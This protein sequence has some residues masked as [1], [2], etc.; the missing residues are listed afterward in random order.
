MLLNEFLLGAECMS[1]LFVA[2]F[3]VRFWLRTRDRLFVF[4]S[5]AFLVMML[6]RIIRAILVQDTEWAPYVYSVRLVAFALIL[7]AIV[8]KNRR[9]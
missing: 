7:V 2:L 1:M 8:D 3:F 5:A 6:E 9:T 4:F